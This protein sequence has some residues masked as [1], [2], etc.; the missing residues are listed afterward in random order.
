MIRRRIGCELSRNEILNSVIF[1]SKNQF[2]ITFPFDGHVAGQ[3]R[4][5]TGVSRADGTLI[6]DIARHSWAG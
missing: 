3:N 5:C 1:I 6:A 4:S 2:F